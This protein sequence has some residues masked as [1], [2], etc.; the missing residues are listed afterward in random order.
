MMKKHLLLL[1]FLWSFTFLNAQQAFPL[2]MEGKYNCSNASN[3]A[4]RYVKADVND[5]TKF[6]FSNDSS[7]TAY[8]RCT[9]K[10]NV[11][12]GFSYF[13]EV[14]LSPWGNGNSTSWNGA[15]FPLTDSLYINSTFTQWPPYH[16]HSNFLSCKKAYI[17]SVDEFNLPKIII[18][19][20][21]TQGFIQLLGVVEGRN[22]Q[23]VD[24]YGRLVKVAYIHPG[25][26]IDIRNLSSGIYFLHLKNR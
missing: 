26:T 22:Y 21:P 18:A 9:M 8:T 6:L 20:N 23:L 24:T 17:T 14:I 25:E 10:A 16:S 7:Y 1:C 13:K 4:T 15:F 12:N 3:S 19:P 2:Q 11:K 5:S